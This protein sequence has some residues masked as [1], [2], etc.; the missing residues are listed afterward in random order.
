M[1]G[2]VR[3]VARN[4]AAQA[5]GKAAVLAIGAASIAVT[6]RYLGAAGYGSFALAPALVQMLGV[7]AHAGLTAVVVREISRAPQRTAEL[8]GNALTVRLALG[9]VVV[10]VAAL[11]ALALPYS[12]DTRRAVLIAGAPFLLGLASSSVAAFF[13]ARLQMWRTPPGWPRWARARTVTSGVSSSSPASR[14]ASRSPST[15][16]TSARTPSSC[17]SS[18]PSTRSASTRLPTGSTSCSR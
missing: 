4:T 3:R 18:G 16:S 15:R 10:A 11:L 8:V 7:L 1:H 2:L 6:T 13:Q 12:P 14:S 9:V 5:A 17:R